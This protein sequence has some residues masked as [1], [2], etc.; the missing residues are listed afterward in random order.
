MSRHLTTRIFPGACGRTR[1][2]RLTRSTPTQP[3]SFEGGVTAV[4]RGGQRRGSSSATAR[5]WKSLS[6]VCPLLNGPVQ[7]PLTCFSHPPELP[8]CTVTKGWN[9]SGHKDP[10]TQAMRVSVLQPPP[11]H[12]LSLCYAPGT[13]LRSCVHGRVCTRT[14]S[15]VTRSSPQGA[16]L[17]V[18][19]VQMQ[20]ARGNEHREAQPHACPSHSPWGDVTVLVVQRRKLR[21]R[22]ARGPSQGTGEVFSS[23]TAEGPGW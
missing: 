10:K 14:A 3:N 11:P 23:Q 4:S 6:G 8:G 12:F 13:P 1:L 20:P 18:C 15:R 5:P 19:Q 16:A 9:H 17:Q 22:E 7:A 21:H 2:G